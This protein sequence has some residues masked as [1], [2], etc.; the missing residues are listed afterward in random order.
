MSHSLSTDFTTLAKRYVAAWNSRDIGK[1]MAFHA[2]DTSYQMDGSKD[3][4]HGRAEVEAKFASQLAAM[5]DI[6]FELKSLHG[7]ADHIVFEA[8]I[9]GTLRDGTPLKLNGI[10]VITIREGRLVAKHSYGVP[11][12]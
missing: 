3:V 9:T 6:S 4:Q 10:D 8:V 7:S 12:R 5:P 1:I 2:E 11:V